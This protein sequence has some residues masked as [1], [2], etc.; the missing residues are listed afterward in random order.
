MPGEQVYAL[1][2][3]DSMYASVERV[4]RPD[5]RT[6]PVIVLS[7]ND[8]CA[9]ARSRE[10]KALGVGMG[11]PWF[12]IRDRP[13]FRTVVALS[14]NFALYGDFS[15][16]M[17]AV[18]ERH[19]PLV[20]PYSIDEC[21]LRLPAGRAGEIA[22]ALREQIGRW[23]GLPVS[24]G[25]A[26]T[27]TLAK[28]ATK[29]AKTT[30][31]GVHDLSTTSPT[32]LHEI[33]GSLPTKDIWGIG[34]RLSARLAAHGV[35]TAA[36]LAALDPGWVRRSYTIV[37]ERTVREL[38]GTACLP[39]E[40]TP[41][42][43]RQL[44]HCRMLGQPVTSE[45]DVA[46]VASSYAQSIAAKLRRHQRATNTLCV[47]LS[48]GGDFYTGPSRNAQ[49]TQTLLAPTSATLPLA[50]TAAR[51][52]RRLWRPGYQFRRVGVMALDLVPDQRHPG[53]WTHPIRDDALAATLDAVTARF[54]RDAIGLGRAGIRQ[55][56]AWAMRQQRLSPA[57]TTRWDQLATVR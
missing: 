52:A 18:I 40:H 33:L 28:V 9:V 27:K 31:T 20:E 13:K 32:A 29:I 42:P 53:L 49:A 4:F 38:A 16:R 22:A 1:V 50:R 30:G 6:A 56:T 10:A 44:L 7:N 46:D 21:F 12:Q 17:L 25:I 41:P 14:S 48:T 55:R 51:L 5:L 36:Q 47:W 26:S 19:T 39:L 8:G 35:T 45:T 57:Y 15:A 23:V 24:V 34:G 11:Q 54:G 37:V 2:D 3:V 43:R